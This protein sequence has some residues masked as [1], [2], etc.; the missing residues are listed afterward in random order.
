[1]KQFILRENPLRDN[2]LSIPDKGRIFKGGYIATV[3]E[4]TFANAWSDNKSVRRFRS[5][6]TL[7]KFLFR[8]YPDAEINLT[9]TCLEGGTFNA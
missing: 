3:T 1:M 5:I 8:N 9:G 4:Y 2:V 7:N 6:P